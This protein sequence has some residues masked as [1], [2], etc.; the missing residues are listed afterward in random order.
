MKMKRVYKRDTKYGDWTL[1]SFLGGGG[2]GEVWTCKNSKG[3]INAI[4]LLKNVKPKPYS[5]FT[6]ETIV[7]E[8]NSD[9]K[10]IIP[11]I[12]KFLPE[13]LIGQTPYFV[14]PFAETSEKKVKGLPI[15]GNRM[16]FYNEYESELSILLKKIEA[17]LQI[18]E[19]LSELHSRQIYHR[20][21]KPANILY[22]DGRFSLADFGLVDYPNKKDI[23]FKNEEI[24]AKWT[25]APEMRRE[26][27]NA[28]ASKADIY[29]LAKT[30][31]IYLTE[32]SKGFDGQYSTESIIHIKKY[33]PK[34]YTSP[35]DILLLNCTDNDPAKRPTIENFIFTLN[36]WKQLA[37]DF[38]ERNHE[39]WFEI[40]N[41]LFPTSIPKR[42]V[43]EDI[44]DIVKVL[45]VVSSY[46]A[47]NH[48]FLP[49]G[50]GLDLEDVRLS[51]E[52][53]CIELDFQLI[54][55]VKPKR[56]LFESF[57]YNHE[58]NYFRLEA[59]ELEPSG[60]Y[61]VEQGEEPYEKTHDREEVTQIYPGQYE[62][63]NYIENSSYREQD[64]YEYES[65]KDMK[66]ITRWFRGSFVIFSKRSVYN[67]TSS[68]YDG[69]HNKMSTDEFRDYIQQSVDHFKEEDKKRPFIEK[70]L[71]KSNKRQRNRQNND[72]VL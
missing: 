1:I 31:W 63:Y 32:N 29:S 68:T 12:D 15:E 22:Y 60:V 17:I 70:L 53:N 49:S 16:G 46:H 34:S 37:E 45:K 64:D 62:D 39:Q 41:K 43:W 61:E 8:K 65:P 66:H 44:N 3:E 7:I 28:D 69:R 35:I 50:G 11:L 5:R 71:D 38:H 24:G 14:M 36:E 59:D 9:I 4:K 56:L 55:V 47:L 57:G 20:D 25:M 27:S 21:I 10:G 48:L 18:S 51:F 6:D 42:V 30:L 40:Q 54:D 23:S 58:W 13:K 19:T 33:Y 2:N 67:R 72:E 26:S 52:E